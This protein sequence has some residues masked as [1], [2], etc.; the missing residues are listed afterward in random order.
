MIWERASTSARLRW[1]S[2]IHFSDVAPAA[3]A[4]VASSAILLTMTPAVPV[5]TFLLLVAVTALGTWLIRR[6]A[7]TLGDPAIGRLKLFFLAKVVVVLLFLKVGWLPGLYAPDAAAGYD[8][9]RYYFGALDLV[10]H[11]FDL[12]IARATPLNYN[13]IVWYYG[14]V[15]AAFGRGPFA[16]VLVNVFV[17]LIATLVLVEAG[18]RIRAER[19]RNDWILGLGMLLPEV[20]WFD[21]LTA[22]ETLMMSLLVI[23]TLS[24]GTALLGA[25]GT[26]KRLAIALSAL[27]VLGI[28]RLPMLLPAVAA[29]GFL[30]VIVR[31]GPR[32]R[33][34]ALGLAIIAA[35]ALLLAPVVGSFLGSKDVHL[36]KILDLV[37]TGNKAMMET[38]SWG[39]RS[40]GRLFVSDSAAGTAAATLPR[41]VLYLV[42]P[43]G[44]VRLDPAGLF[45]GRWT[46]WQAALQGASA[47]LNVALL[48]LALAGLA[49]AL[50]DRARRDD[51]IFHVPCWCVLL[52]V[53]AGNQVIQERYRV[54]GTLLLW[55]CMCLGRT[56][57]RRL[58]V[59][60]Y[61]VWFGTLALGGILVFIYKLAA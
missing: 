42:A 56:A 11:G 51:L 48:P 52:S 34:I 45:A 20:M 53:A 12:S 61:A 29:T 41:L 57:P 37:F 14:L 24:A 16:P 32:R 39:D 31:P 33:R 36:L 17:T 44:A 10:E 60:A 26:G 4:T 55:G 47:L 3:A 40:I 58:L 30:A 25:P 35:A 1:G 8:P 7:R 21:A 59:G 28:V 15:M 46:D 9:Q 54:M 50:V 5:R 38:I 18:Y 19:E 2:R 13:G 6:T 49:V 43:L 22:R 27:L 23:A